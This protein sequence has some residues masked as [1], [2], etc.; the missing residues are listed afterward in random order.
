[1]FF[2]TFFVCGKISVAFGI[3]GEQSILP[4][5]F[6]WCPSVLP[7]LYII[8]GFGFLSSIFSKKFC[9]VFNNVVS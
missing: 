7:T 2:E 9:Q 1:M 8:L 3:L 5:S 4:H 6:G